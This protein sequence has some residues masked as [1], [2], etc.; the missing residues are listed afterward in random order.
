MGGW[1]VYM[2]VKRGSG[3]GLCVS[4][5]EQWVGL[6]LLMGRGSGWGLCVGGQG[7]WVGLCVSREEQWAG[8]VASGERLTY[9]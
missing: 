6:A 9:V 2:L 4:G 7:Q 3:W 5:E 8:H 1:G